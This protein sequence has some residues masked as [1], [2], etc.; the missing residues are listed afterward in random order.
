LSWLRERLDG[1]A[2][3]TLVWHD[4]ETARHSLAPHVLRSDPAH[5]YFDEVLEILAEHGVTVVLD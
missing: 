1:G 3:R 2:R 5:S 4:A